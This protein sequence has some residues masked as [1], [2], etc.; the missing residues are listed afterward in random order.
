M[1]VK[2]NLLGKEVVSFLAAVIF[3]NILFSTTL[4]RHSSLRLRNQDPYSCR[5]KTTEKTVDPCILIFIFWAENCKA[6]YSDL[7]SS[8]YCLRS[9]IR[10]FFHE[11]NTDQELM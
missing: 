5:S 3:L 11:C 8:R 6:K 7:G 2:E 10:Q 1:E 9:I 4:C